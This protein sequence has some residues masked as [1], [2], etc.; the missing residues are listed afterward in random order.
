[1]AGHL[2]FET[3]GSTL[4]ITGGTFTVREELKAA[5]GR[6]DPIHRAWTV[7]VDADIRAVI[8]KKEAE[9]KAMDEAYAKGEAARR[10]RYLSN[11]RIVKGRC[12]AEAVGYYRGGEFGPLCYRC[13]KHGETINSYTGD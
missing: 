8:A 11:P 4:C 12:C 7:S 13:T 3:R 2:R 10:E 1:M 5:G 6:W 9:L